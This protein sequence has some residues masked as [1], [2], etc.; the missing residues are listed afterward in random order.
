[1]AGDFVVFG[2][3]AVLVGLTSVVAQI[4]V[5]FAAHLAPED[6][7]GKVVGQVMSG[8]ILGI[9]LAYVS[10]AIIA[11]LALGAD[12]WRWKFGVS[13]APAIVF[14]LLLLRRYRGVER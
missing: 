7:R 3:M 4:L 1:M 2:A 5:P 11:A 8:L 12:D 14:L 13:A 10:N 9:L 6:E